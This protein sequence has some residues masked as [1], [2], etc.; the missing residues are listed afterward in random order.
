MC[1]YVSKW[2]RI[3]PIAQQ[4]TRRFP[5]QTFSHTNKCLIYRILGSYCFTVPLSSTQ[6]CSITQLVKFQIFQG[7]KL[8]ENQ[9]DKIS[10]CCSLLSTALLGIS[11]NG[12]Y[13]NKQI[14]KRREKI[15]YTNVINVGGI[16]EAAKK[17]DKK[18]V[19]YS[20]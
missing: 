16:N 12:L 8:T 9:C 13:N 5:T 20:E 3:Y 2:K 14:T 18:I 7:V 10:D 4:T 1:L 6:R 11:L 19:Q 15:G 17:L